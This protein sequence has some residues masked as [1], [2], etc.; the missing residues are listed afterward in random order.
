MRVI[1][2]AMLAG[3]G[4][5]DSWGE[6]DVIPPSLTAVL[7]ARSWL[8]LSDAGCLFSSYVGDSDLFLR[9]AAT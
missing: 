3:Q 8:N 7:S 1:I 5:Q 6:L 9:P 2:T 4:R